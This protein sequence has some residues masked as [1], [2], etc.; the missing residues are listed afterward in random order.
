VDGIQRG[1]GV[2]NA[3]LNVSVAANTNRLTIGNSAVSRGVG[4]VLVGKIADA[5]ILRGF[6]PDAVGDGKTNA[7]LQCYINADRDAQPPS[8]SCPNDITVNSDP[9]QTY[10]T[11]VNLGQP[12]VND[13]CGVASVT[14]DAPTQ[15]PAGTT[16]VTWTATD[17]NGNSSTCH[18]FVTVVD[19]SGNDSDGDGLTDWE[20]VHVYGTN[21]NN[22]DSDGDGMS[23]LFEAQYGLNPN[24]NSDAGCKPRYW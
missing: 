7:T 21:P 1:L 9:G 5:R 19:T 6:A 16:T 24:S 18:Q 8:I 23:D 14:N 10:A 3:T 22:P 4:N 17:V 12:T 15:F 2:S 11:N 13:N 20:E